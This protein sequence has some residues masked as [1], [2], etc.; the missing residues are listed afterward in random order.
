MRY[1][2]ACPSPVGRITLASDGR[3]LTGLWLEGQAYFGVGLSPAAEARPDLP[4]LRAAAA[5]LERYF[6]GARPS[7]R[8]LPLGPAGTPFRQ[9]VWSLLLEI[10]YGE[11]LTYG[12]LAARAAQA[13]GRPRMSAQ[14]VGGAAGRNPISIVIPCHRLV[15]ADG[16]LTGYAAGVAVKAR[17]LALEGHANLT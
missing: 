10:P 6:A 4:V 2:A 14:A 17:L 8:E 1:T 7:P 11:T 16:G 15:G 3:R 9:L 12:A 5:W 13:L